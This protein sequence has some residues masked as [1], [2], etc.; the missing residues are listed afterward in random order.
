MS[1]ELRRFK[2]MRRSITVT[3]VCWIVAMVG[4][5]LATRTVGAFPLWVVGW[6]ASLIGWWNWCNHSTPLAAVLREEIEKREKEEQ[7]EQQV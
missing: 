1:E 2:K 5:P 7:E 3:W 4:Y 6:L